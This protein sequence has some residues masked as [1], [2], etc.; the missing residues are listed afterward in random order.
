ML[1]LRFLLGTCR[2]FCMKDVDKGN[3]LCRTYRNGFSPSFGMISGLY[4][5]LDMEPEM[6]RKMLQ[7][8]Q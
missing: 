7:L 4:S 6:E 8:T 5:R 2:L 1:Y 3:D